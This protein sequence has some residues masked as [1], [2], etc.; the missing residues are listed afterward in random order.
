MTGFW[1]FSWMPAARETS[2]LTPCS[3]RCF[4][5][6]K[7]NAALLD[8]AVYPAGNLYPHGGRKADPSGRRGGGVLTMGREVSVPKVSLPK[9]TKSVLILSE[10]KEPDPVPACFRRGSLPRFPPGRTKRIPKEVPV[11]IRLPPAA[12]RRGRAQNP[13]AYRLRG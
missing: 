9:K 3:M 6:R 8:G 13:P 2:S 1:N 4:P 12:R 7:G 11:R 10:R 5:S